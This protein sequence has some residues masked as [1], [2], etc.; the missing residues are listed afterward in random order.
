MVVVRFGPKYKQWKVAFDA[1]S[2]TALGK[3]IITLHDPEHDHALKEI[4]GAA[5]ATCREPEQVVQV[6]AY[7]ITSP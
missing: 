7:V 1:G 6:L 3:S 5:L 2:A 4:N